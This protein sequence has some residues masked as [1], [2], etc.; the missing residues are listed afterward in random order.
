[1]KLVCGLVWAY[2]WGKLKPWS[3]S[4]EI[5]SDRRWSYAYAGT[6]RPIIKGIYVK[7]SGQQLDR[8]Y[9]VF[10]RVSFDFPLPEKVAET[11]E[12]RKLPIEARGA[13]IGESLHWDKVPF[14]INYALLGRLREKVSGVVIVEIMDA[15]TGIA[16]AQAQQNIELLAPN[17][18]R[19]EPEFAEVFAAFV[20]PS[21]PF[22]SEV[23]KEARSLLKSAQE[24]LQLRATSR[25]QREFTKLHTRFTTQCRHSN[26]HTA[27]PRATLKMRRKFVHLR[28]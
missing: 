12:G 20:L 14:S 10:P 11:W 4:I 18:W 26:M 6:R 5:L 9:S 13:K 1:M 22:V 21:D 24:V 8:D 23:V 19:H 7:Q 3:L 28:K 17:E 16:I 27:I 15:D 25:D 2:E